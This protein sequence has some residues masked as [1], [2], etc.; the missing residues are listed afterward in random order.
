MSRAGYL[1]IVVAVILV[2]AGIAIITYLAN[3]KMPVPEGVKEHQPSIDKCGPCS[4]LGCPFYE[5]FHKKEEE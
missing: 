1:I 3:R 4:E 2:L 5:R